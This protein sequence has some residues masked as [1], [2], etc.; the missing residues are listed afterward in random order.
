MSPIRNTLRFVLIGTVIIIAPI[1]SCDPNWLDNDE[2]TVPIRILVFGNSFSNDAVNQNLVELFNA[3]GYAAVIG[4][5]SLSGASLQTHWNNYLNDEH[6]YYYYKISKKGQR[7]KLNYSIENAIAD[8]EWN[9]ASFQQVSH[10]AGDYSSVKPYLDS[11]LCLV[12]REYNSISHLWFQTWAY[13]SDSSHPQFFRYNNNQ[14]LM[15]NRVMDASESII[16]TYK[17]DK[18]IPCGTAIQNARTSYL[19]DGLTR[20]GYHLEK[21]YGRYIAACTWFEAITGETVV[22]NPYYP[23]NMNKELA[24]LCQLAAHYACESPFSVSPMLDFNSR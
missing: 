9:F 18:I 22:G 7:I 11:L 1:L 13:A 4:N 10:L 16:S 17:I 5:L 21:N 14:E 3:A 6:S 19:Q 24:L 2:D 8:E 23:T 15:Y 20:D 12:D